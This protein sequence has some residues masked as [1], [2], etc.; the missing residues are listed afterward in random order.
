MEERETV[1]YITMNIESVNGSIML[2]KY[3]Y[4]IQNTI[5]K[6]TTILRLVDIQN[7]VHIKMFHPKY[8]LCNFDL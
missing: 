7:R 2:S 4:H 8:I 3:A 1:K 6:K 5:N